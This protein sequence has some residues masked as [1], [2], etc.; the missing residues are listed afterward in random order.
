MIVN[1][2]ETA[3]NFGLHAGNHVEPGE[4]IRSR[5]YSISKSIRVVVNKRTPLSW[6]FFSFFLFDVFGIFCLFVC[7]FKMSRPQP[8]YLCGW[9]ERVPGGTRETDGLET[10]IRGAAA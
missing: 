6:L 4:G 10:G 8:C 2:S 7:A 5:A 3:Q 9:I 1:T